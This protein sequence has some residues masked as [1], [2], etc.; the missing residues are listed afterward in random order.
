M[1]VELKS[2]ETYNG[3]L[4]SCDVGLAGFPGTDCTVLI[5]GHARYTAMD[6]H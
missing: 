4:V 2:G 3:H 5:L 6:E 1:L